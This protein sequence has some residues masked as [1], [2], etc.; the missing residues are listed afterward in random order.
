MHVKIVYAGYCMWHLSSSTTL[1]TQSVNFS[2]LNLFVAE[3]A[4]F[5]FVAFEA[6]VLV[7]L[8]E[9]HISHIV[10]LPGFW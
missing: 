10:L 4:V 1:Y 6:V 9:P 8:L 3:V 5:D 2:I 7:G